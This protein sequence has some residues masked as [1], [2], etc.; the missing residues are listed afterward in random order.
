VP[1]IDRWLG[2][3]GSTVADSAPQH[4]RAKAADGREDGMEVGTASAVAAV[5][6]EVADDQSQPTYTRLG[7]PMYGRGKSLIAMIQQSHTDG[8]PAHEDSKAN[9]TPV[10]S[11]GKSMIAWMLQPT[12]RETS[13]PMLAKGALESDEL[14]ACQ[15]SVLPAA[16]PQCQSSIITK[17]RGKCIAAFSGVN[18]ELGA[19]SSEGPNRPIDAQTYAPLTGGH[20]G[21]DRSVR[22]TTRVGAAEELRGGAGIL[23]ESPGDEMILEDVVE[24]DENYGFTKEELTLKRDDYVHIILAAILP[25]A[26]GALPVLMPFGNPFAKDGDNSI[27]I[28][29]AYYF[30][31]TPIGWAVMWVKIVLWNCELWG[32]DFFFPFMHSRPG[33]FSCNSTIVAVVNSTVFATLAYCCGYLIFHNPIPIGTLTFGMPCFV[34]SFINMYFFVVPSERRQTWRDHCRILRCW[35]PFILWFSALGLNMGLV[36]LQSYV[37]SGIQNKYL[38]VLGNVAS[39]LAFIMIRESFGKIPLE[40]FMGDQHMDLSMLWNLGYSAM[41]SSMSDWIFPGIPT[42]AAGLT[43]T[44]SVI[45]MNFALGWYQFASATDPSEMLMCFLN[46]VC[47]VMS[48]WAFLW[49]FTYNVFGPNQRVI[50][51]ISEFSTRQKLEA[52]AMITLNFAINTIKLVLMFRVAATR[53]DAK[54]RTALRAF[55]LT[56]MRRWF[57]LVTWLLVSTCCACGACMVMM[58]DGMDFSFSFRQWYGTWPFVPPQ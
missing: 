8:L 20:V 3:P 43:S 27:A 23:V 7:D 39:Q 37:V 38:Y 35:A 16:S 19:D 5:N 28:N 4:S 22:Q 29:W 21:A 1:H 31:Y 2:R 10:D 57:W 34:V 17:M 41:C 40:W 44:A 32:R 24:L 15:S 46:S 56:A 50:Y 52:I 9:A 26:L 48:G 51:M 42:D 18:E 55:G 47:D 11:R 12:G 25:G 36:W 58:H 53:Y 13:R 30:W 33:N 54:T 6:D 49:I 45:S 14:E